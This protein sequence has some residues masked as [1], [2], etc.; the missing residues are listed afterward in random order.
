MKIY[1]YPNR[2]SLNHF[3]KAPLTMDFQNPDPSSLIQAQLQAVLFFLRKQLTSLWLTSNHHI[4][5]LP[6]GTFCFQHFFLQQRNPF[7]LAQQHQRVRLLLTN[8]SPNA[9]V[10]LG[11]ILLFT[12]AH[13]PKTW[14]I[15]WTM[16]KVAAF[17]Q[18]F[19]TWP[20]NICNMAKY[21]GENNQFCLHKPRYK[22]CFCEF[23]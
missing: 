5:W 18:T 15:C 2:C 1:T 12:S 19:A 14:V 6:H 17:I 13:N 21:Q 10:Q 22:G 11:E 16:T 20:S 3:K 9:A 23:W 4:F 8:L 7:L